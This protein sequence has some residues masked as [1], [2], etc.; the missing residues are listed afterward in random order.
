MAHG[1]SSVV[2]Y[3]GAFDAVRLHDGTLE[4]RFFATRGQAMAAGLSSRQAKALFQDTKEDD[5]ENPPCIRHI[6]KKMSDPNQQEVFCQKKACT[7]TACNVYSL[8]K[9]GDPDK[10][11]KKQKN[12]CDYDTDHFYKCECE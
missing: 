6:R 9:D 11:W 7:K 3:G 5:D 12:P 10:D 1:I 4:I 2:L 8:P